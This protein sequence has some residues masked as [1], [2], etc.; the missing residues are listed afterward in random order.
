MPAGEAA[1]RA[2]CPVGPLRLQHKASSG[3]LE[4][5]VEGRA[6]QAPGCRSYG[7]YHGE[8]H[9]PGAARAFPP[10]SPTLTGFSVLCSWPLEGS[11]SGVSFPWI[12]TGFPAAVGGPCSPHFWL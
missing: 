3:V 9:G 1:H 10:A 2:G 7:V 6:W 11:V 5:P 4:L 12:L 8:A